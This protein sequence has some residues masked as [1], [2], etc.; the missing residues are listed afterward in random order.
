MDTVGLVGCKPSPAD[1][2]ARSRAFQARHARCV[3]GP[4]GFRSPIL[5]ATHG[6][7]H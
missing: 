7:E 5:D 4:L 2:L 1:V 3:L 6:E